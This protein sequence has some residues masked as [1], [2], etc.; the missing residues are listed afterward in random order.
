MNATELAEAESILNELVASMFEERS[1]GTSF[2]SFYA[3]WQ[4][5]DLENDQVLDR[6][7]RGRGVYAIELV[8]NEDLDL[9]QRGQG[10]VIHTLDELRGLLRQTRAV[11]AGFARA[12]G[13][14]ENDSVFVPSS[15]GRFRR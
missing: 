5:T 1:P 10:T 4:S 3:D 14:F 11:K 7:R 8:W 9:V 13:G 15:P 6:F 12:R 2:W